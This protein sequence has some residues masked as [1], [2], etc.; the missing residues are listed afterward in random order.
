[1]EVCPTGIDIRNGTQLECV[2]C[3][4]CIDACDEIMVK[5][6]RPKGLIRYASYN[7]ILKSV[8]FKMTPRII[9]Y[10]SILMVL[11]IVL[12][13][14]L[15]TRSD[16]ETTILRTPGMLYQETGQGSITN[17]YNVKIIN[18]TFEKK[19]IQ[20]KLEQPAGKI[21][22]I[23]GNINIPESEIAETSFFVEIEKKNIFA[24]SIPIKIG[25]YSG[26]KLLEE[27]NT[28]FMGP[29]KTAKRKKSI[30]Q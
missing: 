8:K 6:N 11:M 24:V 1:V 10:T 22:M 16:I 4:A 28:N 21:N 27:V 14:M 20:L 17:L 15:L 18:K 26:E 5:V 2:N 13:S 9:G 19:P 30:N 3:T 29:Q 25:V 23:G 12:F 7:S